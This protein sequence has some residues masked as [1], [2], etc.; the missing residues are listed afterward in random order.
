MPSLLGNVEARVEAHFAPGAGAVEGQ[1]FESPQRRADVAK[2][3]IVLKSKAGVIGRV[4]KQDASASTHRLETSQSLADQ[5]LAYA[6][7]L[8]VRPQRHRSKP[9]PAACL[10]VDRDWRKGDMADDFTALRRH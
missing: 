5:G 3:W 10:V 2:V 7:P 4:A 8:T 6:R 9:L 1:A